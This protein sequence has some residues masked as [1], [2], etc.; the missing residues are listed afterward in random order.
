[1]IKVNNKQ[2]FKSETK[3]KLPFSYA[4]C[5]LG[6]PIPLSSNGW[7]ELEAAQLLPTY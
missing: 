4:P 2:F 3:L 6:P 7:D 1:M 5:I